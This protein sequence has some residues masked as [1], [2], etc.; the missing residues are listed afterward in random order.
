MDFW[1]MAK[2]AGLSRLNEWMELKRYFLPQ[3]PSWCLRDPLMQ[4]FQDRLK[5]LQG[6]RVVWG[7]FV[8]ANGLLFSPGAF[9]SPATMLYGLDPIWDDNPRTLQT[10]AHELYAM[11]GSVPQEPQ[12]REIAAHLTSEWDRSMVM[13]VPEP[14]A[15]GYELVVT[16]VMVHRRHLPSGYLTSGLVPLVINPRETPCTMILPARYWPLELLGQ[17]PHL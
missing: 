12:F 6:G 11:K 15:R 17:I 3:P 4:L 7:H 14:I 13:R 16:S 2:S 10:I 5:I 9:D 8:Q 1:D